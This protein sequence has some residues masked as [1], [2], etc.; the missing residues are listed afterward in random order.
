MVWPSFDHKEDLVYKSCFRAALGCFA[1]QG[2]AVPALLP[3]LLIPTEECGLSLFHCLCLGNLVH[4]STA[5]EDERLSTEHM[6]TVVRAQDG[7]WL[8]D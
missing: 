5:L 3:P 1:T 8:Q 4:L 6:R 2:K 7:G